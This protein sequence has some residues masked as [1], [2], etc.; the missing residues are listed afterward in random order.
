M[1]LCNAEMNPALCFQHSYL[2]EGSNVNIMLCFITWKHLWLLQITRIY[3]QECDDYL[4][5]S[6]I[7]PEFWLLQRNQHACFQVKLQCMITHVIYYME[8]Y[9]T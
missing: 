6:G 4:E 3:Y 5:M 9:T 2:F 1:P 7:S 8:D